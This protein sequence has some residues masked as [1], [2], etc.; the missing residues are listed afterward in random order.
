MCK[1]DL[2]PSPHRT[3]TTRVYFSAKATPSFALPSEKIMVDAS[4]VCIIIAKAIIMAREA[5]FV[6]DS[7]VIDEQTA[8]KSHCAFGEDTDDGDGGGQRA[9]SRRN[10]TA[11]LRWRPNG[12]CR[13]RRCR[14]G[15][16]RRVSR[17]RRRRCST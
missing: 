3:S 12:C 10:D 13:D 4:T 7:T 9:A 1:A 2:E 15:G 16:A 17:S 5:K 6:V 8:A 14:R 11:D